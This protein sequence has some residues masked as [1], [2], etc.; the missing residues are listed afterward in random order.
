MNIIKI[1]KYY[2]RS[3]FKS[4]DNIDLNNIKNNFKN[5]FN[6]NLRLSKKEIYKEKFYIFDTINKMSI[7]TL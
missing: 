1:Q 6:I 4:N 2:V 3:L 5:K 7:N